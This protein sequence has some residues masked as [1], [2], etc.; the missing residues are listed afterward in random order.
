MARLGPFEPAPALAVAVSGGPDSLALALLARDWAEGQGGS[1]LAL[2]ADHGL[3]PESAVEAR[4]TLARLA[5]QGI[6]ARLLT[7]HGLAHGPGLAARAR[8]A[9]HAAL[10]EAC[11]EAGILHLLLGHHR[12]DQ[13]ETWRMRARAGSGPRGLAAMAGLAE[14]DRVRL[15]RPLLAVTPGD[16]RAL[17]AGQGIG[18]VE[19][20]SNHD[21]STL[22][23]RLR[24]ELDDPDGRGAAVASLAG[25]AAQQGAARAA[26]DAALAAIL[27]AR[28]GLHPAGWAMLSPGALPPAALEALLRCIAGRLHPLPSAGVAALAASPRAATLGGARLVAAKQDAGWLVLREA[29]AMQ[30]PIPASAGAIWDGR[31]R[32]HRAEPGLTLGALGP[33]AAGLRRLRPDWPSALL[34][35]LPALR[36]GDALVAVPA[37]GFCAG[38]CRVDLAFTPPA[39]LCGAPFLAL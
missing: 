26:Q 28:V 14:R 15:L 13:A 21:P 9:R 6:E 23:A 22:R 4:L 36:R 5:G 31:F 27:A 10:A 19:D 3:R 12:R 17:L 24:A 35:T 30:P 8:A 33:Q 2:V 39:P 37:L 29:A 20:P 18:W 25:A 34:H 11:A 32:L 16:L 1:V 38:E 7:L